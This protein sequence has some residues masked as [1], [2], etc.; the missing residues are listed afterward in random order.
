M[1]PR[2]QRRW[3]TRFGRWVS[4]FGVRRLT[5]ALEQGGQPVTTYAV[6]Q[7]LAG[8]TFPRPDRIDAIV[9]LSDGKLTQQDIHQHRVIVRR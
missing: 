4:T 1:P 7:W 5:R 2:I 8:R 6:H 9:T 3:S